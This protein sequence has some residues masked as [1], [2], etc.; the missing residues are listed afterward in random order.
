MNSLVLKDSVRTSIDLTVICVANEMSEFSAFLH[1]SNL[2]SY[3]V[4]FRHP[5]GNEHSN[6]LQK[7]KLLDDTAVTRGVLQNIEYT[8]APRQIH[9][10]KSGWF[11]KTLQVD[12]DF[13]LSAYV[14]TIYIRLR[15]IRYVVRRSPGTKLQLGGFPTT[16][17]KIR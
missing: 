8:R 13:I 6:I 14:D 1:M 3:I 11:K 10:K 15:Q 5:R 17:P 9:A 16:V 2:V 12:L 7:S 4:K